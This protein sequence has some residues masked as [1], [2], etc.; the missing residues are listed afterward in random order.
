MVT[1]SGAAFR[2]IAYSK[3][4]RAAALSRRARSRKSKVSPGLSRHGTDTSTRP[5]P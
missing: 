5:S 1:F 3:N 4:L 2:S